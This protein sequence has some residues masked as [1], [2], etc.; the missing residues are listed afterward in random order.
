MIGTCTKSSIHIYVCLCKLA[1]R[2]Q[3]FSTYY[4]CLAESQDVAQKETVVCFFV[5]S[6]VEHNWD[7]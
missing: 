2:F 7:T 3:V 5:M 6:L 1:M 4:F